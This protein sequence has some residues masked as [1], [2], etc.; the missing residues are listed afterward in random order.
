MMNLTRRRMTYS[1]KSDPNTILL[2]HGKDGA[3]DASG[4]NVPLVINGDVIVNTSIKKFNA[5]LRFQSGTFGIKSVST[6]SEMAFGTKNF[7]IDFWLNYSSSATMVLFNTGTSYNSGGGIIIAVQN[8]KVT[9]YANSGV[10]TVIDAP[11]PSNTWTHIAVIRDGSQLK[12]YVNGVLISSMAF[13]YSLQ[14]NQAF[15]IGYENANT[16]T[17]P[18][19][20]YLE[21]FRVS[22][23]ARWTSNFTVP[24]SPFK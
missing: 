13:S 20:G 23:I 2:I 8:N 21:E 4:Y 14:S 12:L 24:T 11:I 15:I 10:G 3:V 6:Y 22:N 1:K 16:G 18:F 7:T 19:N 5:S 9:T 17:L